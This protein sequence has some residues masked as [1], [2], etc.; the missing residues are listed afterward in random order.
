M[1]FN[2]YVNVTTQ[3]RIEDWID[4]LAQLVLPRCLMNDQNTKIHTI[5]S[6][7]SGGG[8]A[9]LHMHHATI[10]HTIQVRV[11]PAV[12]WLYTVI[13]FS[14]AQSNKFVGQEYGVL[15]S[16]SEGHDEASRALEP[17]AGNSN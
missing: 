16:T 2:L 3:D 14:P 9:K 8:K 7:A 1:Q 11:F 5:R 4:Q 13:R 12:F 6:T 17:E 15:R 10:L